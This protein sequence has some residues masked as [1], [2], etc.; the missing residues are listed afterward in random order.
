MKKIEVWYQLPVTAEMDYIME[1]A[2]KA[3]EIGF[4]GVSNEDH[5]WVKGLG[6]GCRPECWTMLTAIAAK[7]EKLKVTSLVTCIL[8]RNPS[9]LA[10][11]I[12]TLD[13]I[14]KGRVLLVYGACWWREELESFGYKW[15]EDKVRVERTIEAIKI[16]KRLFTENEVTFKGKYYSVKKCRLEPKP[17][18][19]PHPPI[20]CGGAGYKM[21]KFAAQYVD[22][23]VMPI[24]IMKDV[25][26]YLRKRRIVEKYVGERDFI[27]GI[28]L[29]FNPDKICLENVEEKL[30][31]YIRLGVTWIN[32]RLDP[33][34]R[35]LELIERIKPLILS[36]KRID[37]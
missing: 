32:I 28:A 10:K 12:T 5:L 34:N 27:Y 23:W 24:S 14:S 25:D 36:I 4:D 9:L 19:K 35:N 3:E 1:C 20:F 29:R 7:T 26:E 17:Y 8:H 2:L 11:I 15:E 22:G 13:W 18:Q 31:E 37:I 30:K 6:A 33:D 21:R 16:I